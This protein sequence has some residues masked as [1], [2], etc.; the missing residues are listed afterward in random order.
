MRDPE[1]EPLL[2]PLA[3]EERYETWHI[4]LPSGSLAGHG[5][6]GIELLRAM[7][8]TRP[9]ARLLAHVPDR[10]LDGAYA[11]VARNRGRLGR[12]VPDGPAPRRT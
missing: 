5:T 9:A 3:E 11:L 8:L 7:A 12:I 2:A 10:V 1:A 4:A 6:G